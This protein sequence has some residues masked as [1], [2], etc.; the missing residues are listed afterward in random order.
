MKITARNQISG[1]IVSL[2][3]GAVNAVVKV[4]I[5]GGNVV[6]SS[7]TEGAILDLG[8]AVGA[9]LTPT[10][11]AVLAAYRSLEAGLVGSAQNG[12]LPELAGLLRDAP[13]REEA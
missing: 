10:G 2:T 1:T 8:L 4:D 12:A 5:G 6:T 7:I 9:R 13:L 11:K 3:P